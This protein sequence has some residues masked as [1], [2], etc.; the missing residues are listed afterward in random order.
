MTD[1]EAIRARL[2]AA[3]PGPWGWQATGEKDNSWSLGTVIDDDEQPMSGEVGDAGTVVEFVA[4]GFDHVPNA[5]FIAHA[6]EGIA[7]LLRVADAAEALLAWVEH[8]GFNS[9][10][11]WCG[12][13]DHHVEGCPVGALRAA[14]REGGQR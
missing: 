11:Q 2:A 5:D 13:F 9:H 3:T 6:P 4:E 1:L 14:L 12:Q 8:G 10:C 7:H